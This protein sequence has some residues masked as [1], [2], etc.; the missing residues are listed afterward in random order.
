[1]EFSFQL[2]TCLLSK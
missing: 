2:L 1:M